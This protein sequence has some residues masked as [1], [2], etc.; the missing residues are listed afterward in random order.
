M[1]SSF[2]ILD[3]SCQELKKQEY[4]TY[5][6]ELKTL[7]FLIKN[8]V[9]IIKTKYGRTYTN[10]KFKFLLP[11][12]LPLILTACGDSYLD[13]ETEE[14]IEMIEKSFAAHIKSTALMAN[15]DIDITPKLKLTEFEQ[16]NVDENSRECKYTFD[17]SVGKTSGISL[18][19]TSLI[20]KIDRGSKTHKLDAIFD[21]T[22]TLEV[23]KL[24]IKEAKL[25]VLHDE[26]Q[27]AGFATAKD[28]LEYKKE[29]A[30][31]AKEKMAESAKLAKEKMAKEK[32][33]KEKLE[34]TKHDMEVLG[35]KTYIA[36]CAACHQQSGLGL[37]PS[38]PALKGNP[39][40]TT[41]AVKDN[42]NIVLNGKGR[43][44]QG[45]GRQLSLKEIAAVVTYQ[46]NAWGNNTGDFVLPSDVEAEK[47]LA[48]K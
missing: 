46:R 23:I 27:K 15:K 31:L 2:R 33:A 45:Y 6:T 43:M 11:V 3:S 21:V 8:E 35:E 25:I 19:S 26:A 13:C 12:A 1:Y 4:A 39:I 38:F 34:N 7:L 16:M 48:S 5:H 36:H 17:V 20:R 9:I 41:G 10:M 37:P 18:K 28:H 29:Q 47:K 24:T 44:M 14:N 42:I 30:I 40:T 32:L 22:S